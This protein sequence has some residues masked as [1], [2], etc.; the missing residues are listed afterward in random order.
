[1]GVEDKCYMRPASVLKLRIK[2]KGSKHAMRKAHES[3]LISVTLRMQ[4][5]RCT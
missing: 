1:M 2:L 3:L 5:Q 4:M